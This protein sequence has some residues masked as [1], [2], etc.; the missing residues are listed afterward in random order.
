MA[1]IRVEYRPRKGKG[2]SAG[3]DARSQGMLKSRLGDVALAIIL[4]VA[5]VAGMGNLRSTREHHARNRHPH[6]VLAPRHGQAP[7][8]GI[9]TAGRDET[10][11]ARG[12]TGAPPAAGSGIVHPPR[13]SFRG[14]SGSNVRTRGPPP[15]RPVELSSRSD[16]S[17]HSDSRSVAAP[18][19]DI[20]SSTD[21][22]PWSTPPRLSRRGSAGCVEG[23]PACRI[24]PLAGGVS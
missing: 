24:P 1:T 14:R 16:S 6:S 15:R 23:A 20:S 13:Q 8:P 7:K 12:G 2:A 5:F 9:R 11:L 18:R 10:A 19:P 22:C 21:P 4:S 3:R 17:Y